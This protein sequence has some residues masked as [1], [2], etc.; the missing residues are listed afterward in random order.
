MFPLISMLLLQRQIGKYNIFILKGLNMVE[1]Q[2]KVKY[3]MLPTPTYFL[4][5]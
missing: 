1:N 5:K 3:K 4:W 2:I